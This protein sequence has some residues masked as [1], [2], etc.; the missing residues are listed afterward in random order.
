MRKSETRSG[1]QDLESEP[2]TRPAFPRL[3]KNSVKRFLPKTLL[4]EL[5]RFVSL[6][7]RERALYLRLKT[8]TGLG[9]TRKP[10]HRIKV[11]SLLFVCFGNIMRSPM[12]EALMNRALQ[13]GAH[14]NLSVSSAGLNATAGRE[15]HPR[16]LAAAR[17]YGISLDSH[18]ARLLTSE[19]VEAADLVL[20]MD[21]QNYVQLLSRY[22]SAKNKIAMLAASSG[23]KFRNAEIKDPYYEGPEATSKCYAI[24]ATCIENLLQ[25]LDRNP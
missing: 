1:D 15:V 17:E 9:F 24:L 10:L 4:D 14:S 21:F 18:R 12:C 3:V 5:Q 6:E 20:V 11:R 2:A 25:E 7:P 19:M 23:S 16:A 13:S 8:S 22:P